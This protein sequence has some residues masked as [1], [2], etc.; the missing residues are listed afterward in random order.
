MIVF[1]IFSEKIKAFDP[2]FLYYKEPVIYGAKGTE[3]AFQE[4]IQLLEEKRL[5]ILPM[6]T[7]RF[8]LKE[9][10]DAFKTFK[11]KV[12]DALRIVIEIAP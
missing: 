9:A 6:I 7:H 4:A 3:G 2:S 8:P 12:S 10:A 11:D 5:K 1:G